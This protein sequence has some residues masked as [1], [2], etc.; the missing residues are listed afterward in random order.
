MFRFRPPYVSGTTNPISIRQMDANTRKQLFN[1]MAEAI[2]ED[3]SKLRE[4]LTAEPSLYSSLILGINDYVDNLSVDMQKSDSISLNVGNADCLSFTKQHEI[5][6]LHLGR[7]YA[8]IN[9]PLE[10]IRRELLTDVATHPDIYDPDSARIATSLLTSLG[11][12]Y[13]L[14]E[15]QSND[16]FAV[17]DPSIPLQPDHFL[18]KE[19]F[20]LLEKDEL[21]SESSP[22]TN[23][24]MVSEALPETNTASDTEEIWFTSEMVTGAKQMEMDKITSRLS[25]TDLNLVIKNMPLEYN[26]RTMAIAE[27]KEVNEKEIVSHLNA[28]AVPGKTTL[29]P[30]GVTKKT[31]YGESQHA[32]LGVV[33]A[34]GELYIIDSQ[35]NYYKGVKTLHSG[36]QSWM[37]SKNCARFTLYTLTQLL[38]ISN[39]GNSLPDLEYMLLGIKP[40]E[41]EK[42][43][44]L[45]YCYL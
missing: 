15:P 16:T 24:E 38:E 45:Y 9:K 5:T 12:G 27:A 40:P 36:F 6:H 17:V 43:Q 22:L 32:V 3:M 14:V 41:L 29:I 7:E 8:L 26:Q 35:H 42:L 13:E 19:R 33:D 23:W 1:T 44:H 18:K 31:W 20:E 21:S 4:S 30:M 10:K 34:K 2:R 39:K 37:D 25:M 28:H 11:E